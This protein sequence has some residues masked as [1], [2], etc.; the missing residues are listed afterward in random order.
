MGDVEV[1]RESVTESVDIEAFVA[2]EPCEIVVGHLACPEY[3]TC[4]IVVVMFPEEH[5]SEL[6][7]RTHQSAG[8][9]IGEVVALN[10]GEESLK[11][12]H[13]DIG[14]PGADLVVG[15]SEQELRI[16][17]CEDRPV[18]LGVE[19]VLLE[20]LFIGND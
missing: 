17:K 11:G 9:L 14:A 1:R 4:C 12:M 16:D 2:A 15:K 8:E 7:Y 3:L 20:S 10:I 5:W 18:E 19:T 13:H 6:D